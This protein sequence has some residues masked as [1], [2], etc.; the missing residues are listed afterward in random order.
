MDADEIARLI[1]GGGDVDCDRE[2]LEGAGLRSLAPS[3]PLIEFVP[4]A[5]KTESYD[6]SRYREAETPL[7]RLF[8]NLCDAILPP[9]GSLGAEAL[10]NCT[11]P[12]GRAIAEVERFVGR[13]GL[14][15]W[16]NSHACFVDNVTLDFDVRKLDWD[17]ATIFHNLIRT[18][19]PERFAN[20]IVW[21]LQES[22][23]MKRALQL[24]NAL[25]RLRRSH[26]KRPL[27]ALWNRRR[28]YAG[29]LF[30]GVELTSDRWE[31]LVNLS[32]IELNQLIGRHV[33][34]AH[35]SPL[36]TFERYPRPRG[37]SFRGLWFKAGLRYDAPLIGLWLQLFDDVMRLTSGERQCPECQNMFT[38]GR[39]DQ[40]YCSTLCAGRVR[41]R[42][43][44]QEE[45]SKRARGRKRA[46]A[47][48]ERQRRKR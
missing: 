42:R 21:V 45:A 47:A 28:G 43:W 24:C 46:V 14:L 20:N 18:S 35:P 34:L 23:V 26:D 17:R 31:M 39:R 3:P 44:R 9:D 16:S 7:Y 10:A 6:P 22:L 1:L 36:T 5:G 11:A 41:N 40:E 8:A 37:G 33:G 48:P 19:T 38:P 15:D 4:V 32:V 29:R 2:L 27:E 25:I 13:F 30:D 12:T